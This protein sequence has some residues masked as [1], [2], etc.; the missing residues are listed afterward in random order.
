ML[1]Y[2]Q[3]KMYAAILSSYF[4]CFLITANMLSIYF[5]LIIFNALIVAF[6]SFN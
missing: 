6:P 5:A 1:R 3:I 4:D 2:N